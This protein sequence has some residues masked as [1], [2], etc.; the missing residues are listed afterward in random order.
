MCAF[1]PR[2]I[3]LLVVAIACIGIGYFLGYKHGHNLADHDLRDLTKMD[4]HDF[5]ILDKLQNDGD[6]NR[7]EKFVHDLILVHT[8]QYDIPFGNETIT[9]QWFIKDLAAGHALERQN[10][11]AWDE[12]M[13]TNRRPNTALEPTATAP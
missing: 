2:I 10:Q 7:M 1:L 13:R 12:Y 8:R 5:L 9:N 3:L 4:L 6:T 11:Q